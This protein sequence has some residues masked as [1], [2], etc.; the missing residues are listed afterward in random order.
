M[1]RIMKRIAAVLATAAV[2]AACVPARPGARAAADEVITS[3]EQLNQA[4]MKI[5][6]GTGSAS[7]EIAEKEFTNA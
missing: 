5:G 1:S 2:L 3:R 6:V 4:G 7:A